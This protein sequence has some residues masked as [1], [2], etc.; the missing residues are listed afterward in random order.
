MAE[1]EYQGSDFLAEN[2]N[3]TAKAAADQK[4]AQ[5]SSAQPQ[6]SSGAQKQ[7]GGLIGAIKKD[8]GKT[9]GPGPAPAAAPAQTSQPATNGGGLIGAIKGS[10]HD[11]GKV[12]ETAPYQLHKGEE[13]IPAKRASE[14]RKVFAQ[15]GAQ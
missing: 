10:F 12:P 9:K 6:P 14:Y 1:E 5:S 2:Q 7:K 11:G 4:A 13:V 8:L 15:R 3:E